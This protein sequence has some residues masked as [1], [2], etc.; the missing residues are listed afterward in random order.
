MPFEDLPSPLEDI[1]D[2]IKDI[3]EFVTGRSFDD[4][5]RDTMFR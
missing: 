2:A 1:L 4:Y 3:Q 5:S